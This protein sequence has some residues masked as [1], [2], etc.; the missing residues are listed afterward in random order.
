V[1]Y[2]DLFIGGGK[3]PTFTSSS[4]TAAIENEGDAFDDMMGEA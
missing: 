3:K 1:D 4:K 2:C